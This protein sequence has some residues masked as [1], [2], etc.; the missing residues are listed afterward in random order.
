MQQLKQKDI[1]KIRDELVKHNDGKCPVSGLDISNGDA[2]LDHAH[3]DSE[4][5]ETVEGQVRGVLHKFANSLEGSWRARYLRSGLANEITFEELLINMYTYLMEYREPMLH[6]SH[7]QKPRK[8]MK[9]SYNE[10]KREVNNANRYL[11]RKIK[12]PDYPKSKR[13]TKKLKELYEKFG[14]IPKYYSGNVK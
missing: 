6:P 9:S 5:S 3:Q 13:L 1:K 8:L 10:L 14:I 7:A 2:C 11:K 12:M 4:I